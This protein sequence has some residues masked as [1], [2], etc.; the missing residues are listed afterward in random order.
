MASCVLGAV[1]SNIA[2]CVGLMT[3]GPLS[4]VVACIAGFIFPAIEIILIIAK[5]KNRFDQSKVWRA[6]MS[7]LRSASV[8]IL[9]SAAWTII[10]FA[11]FNVEEF[12]AR[13]RGE[14][15]EFFNLIKPGSIIL[16]LAMLI[17]SNIKLF[18]KLHPAVWIFSC[19]IVGVIFSF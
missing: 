10:Q 16:L 2:S 12:Y 4:V 14:F 18:K 1:G 6:F 3:A 5:L 9:L 17:L 15:L 11:I 19:V 7:S 13:T 8:A